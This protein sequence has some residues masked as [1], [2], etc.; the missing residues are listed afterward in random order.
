MIVQDD[1]VASLDIPPID[2]YA[3]V[4]QIFNESRDVIV[5]HFSFLV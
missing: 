2:F 5:I 4:R 1:V 3:V